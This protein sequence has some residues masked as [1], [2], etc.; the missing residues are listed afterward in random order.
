MIKNLQEELK[1]AKQAIEE[2]GLT[3]E[4]EKIAFSKIMDNLLGDTSP[5]RNQ[6]KR[7]KRATRKS[8]N[9]KEEKGED[10]KLEEE[11]KILIN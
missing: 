4:L 2:A 7:N 6:K 1:N 11:N 3:G 8:V 10:K 9:K 5:V